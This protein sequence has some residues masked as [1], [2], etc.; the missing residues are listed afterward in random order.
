MVVGAQV[1]RQQTGLQIGGVRGIRGLELLAE[2]ALRG[3]LQCADVRLDAIEEFFSLV[4]VCNVVSAE[5]V[6]VAVVE[7]EASDA[8]ALVVPTATADAGSPASSMPIVAQDAPVASD[9]MTSLYV[10]YLVLSP[11]GSQQL[12][13]F[14]LIYTLFTKRI[15]SVGDLC[16]QLES[17]LSESP[18]IP[19]FPELRNIL[20]II[21][22]GCRAAGKT[23]PS[24]ATL[25]SS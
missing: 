23:A 16:L 3:P 7:D 17:Q 22:T 2:H 24:L 25:G 20:G 11:I 4:H 15:K 1:E 10:S 12:C 13:R 8:A 5:G 19:L 6:M 18:W 14:M 21:I 9:A